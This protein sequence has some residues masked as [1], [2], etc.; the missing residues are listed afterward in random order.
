MERNAEFEL[1]R[2]RNALLSECDW[3]QFADS[4]LTAEQKAE[5]ATYRQALRDLPANSNPSFDENENLIGY[6]LPQK[7]FNA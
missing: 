3:T 5:W 2:L 6:T 1:R 4:P 7:P